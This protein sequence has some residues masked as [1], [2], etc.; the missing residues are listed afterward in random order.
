MG[1]RDF[2]S[3]FLD[4]ARD[5]LRLNI[6]SIIDVGQASGRL[7]HA[8]EW[9]D[10]LDVD[11]LYKRSTAEG[12]GV[13]LRHLLYLLRETLQGLHY[14]HTAKDA[15]GRPM[16]IVHRDISPG[17]ILISRHGAVK[18]ADFGVAV[19]SA[20]HTAGS[21]ESLAGKPHYFA[22]ELWRGSPASPATD[23]FALGVTFYEIFRGQPLFSRKVALQALAF[24]ICEFSVD[25]L[26]END[27]PPGRPEH[28]VRRSLT[29][30][31]AL[32]LRARVP[33]GRQ[34]L[35]LR[36]RHSPAGPHF[37]DYIQAATPSSP[38]FEGRRSIW[39]D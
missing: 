35:R 19:S 24:E 23:I 32:R 38:A 22:P 15:D 31:R 20:A 26:V 8:M 1:D 7:P 10:G 4:E 39:K 16:G 36:G 33:R 18:L 17:N 12:A 27:L 5:H 14:A 29:K 34:R 6:V 3:L 9:I 21:A 11:S 37:A 13:P 25:E 2:R 30:R 28:I